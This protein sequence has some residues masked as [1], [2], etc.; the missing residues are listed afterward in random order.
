MFLIWVVYSIIGSLSICLIIS[1]DSSQQ[2][3]G[4]ALLIVMSFCLFILYRMHIDF[5]RGRERRRNRLRYIKYE[6]A[7][8]EYERK[9]R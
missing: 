4:G 2:V 9:L 7:M 1:G 5:K 8:I 6:T 3:A